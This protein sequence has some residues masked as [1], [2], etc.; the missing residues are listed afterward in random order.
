MLDHLLAAVEILQVKL[1]RLSLDIFRALFLVLRGVIIGFL[2]LDIGQ[3]GAEKVVD[4][5]GVFQDLQ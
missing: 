5:D 1:D 4:D 3:F 2:C